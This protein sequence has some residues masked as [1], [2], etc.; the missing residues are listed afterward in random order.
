MTIIK[1]WDN[2]EGHRREKPMSDEMRD[3]RRRIKYS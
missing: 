3:E 2:N 1:M